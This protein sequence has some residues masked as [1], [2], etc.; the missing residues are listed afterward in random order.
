VRLAPEEDASLPRLQ[1]LRGT[2]VIDGAPASPLL[3]AWRR[4]AAVL[5]RETGF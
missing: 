3:R 4:I 5:I 1:V 2:V